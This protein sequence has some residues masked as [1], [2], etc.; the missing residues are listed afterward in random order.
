MCRL[1]R[2]SID[3]GRAGSARRQA[4]RHFLVVE[5]DANKERRRLNLLG[6]TAT[7]EICACPVEIACSTVS[8][9]P[10]RI[11]PGSNLKVTST[12]W[13]AAI[14]RASFCVISTPINVP[15]VSMNAITGASGRFATR[16]PLRKATLVA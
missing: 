15:D 7:P 14:Y 13:P 11:T 12:G 8:T 2:F 9:L 16:A 4:L 5:P 10:V 6:A 1:D 3:R